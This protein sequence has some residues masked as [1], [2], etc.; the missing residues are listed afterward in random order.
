MLS[1]LPDK[2]VQSVVWNVS[3]MFIEPL[4]MAMDVGFGYNND[5]NHLLFDCV[6]MCLNESTIICILRVNGNG[7][8]TLLHLFTKDLQPTIGM[9]HHKIGVFGSTQI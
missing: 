4:I 9:I 2:V 1:P 3:Y 5:F 7:K 8:S 6:D